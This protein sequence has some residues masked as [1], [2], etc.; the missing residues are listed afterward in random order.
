[1]TDREAVVSAKR[2][3]REQAKA[4]R[5]LL[6]PAKRAE[7]SARIAERGLDFLGRSPPAIASAFLAIGEEINP[8]PLMARLHREGWQ[9]ALPVM[10]GKGKPLQFRAWTPGAALRTV[11]WGIREPEESAPVVEPDVLLVPLLAFD[12]SGRRLGYGGGFYDRTLQRLRALKPVTAV[13]LAFA[14]QEVDAVPHLDYDE[15]LD[16]VLTPEG[17]IRCSV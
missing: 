14:S 10:V 6:S 7:G 15:R 1:M 16:W 3:L 12:R 5:A 8:G 11:M 4:A 9:V 2:R 13:G 17:P